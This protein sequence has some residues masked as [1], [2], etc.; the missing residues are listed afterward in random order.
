MKQQP[1]VGFS[2]DFVAGYGFRRVGGF[3]ALVGSAGGLRLLGELAADPDRP[4]ARPQDAYRAFLY[5][6]QP[7]WTLR[8]LQISW[9]DP[10]PRLA[11]QQAVE[12]WPAARN[13][14]LAILRDG[15]LLHLQQY[16]LPFRRRTIVE[17][18]L[19]PAGEE[20]ALDWWSAASGMFH[21]YQVAFSYLGEE[22]IVEIARRAL[23]PGF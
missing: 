7:G 8:C 17:F 14:G 20:E 5:S 23:N 13:E 15:L 10:D 11:F 1:A 3:I 9:P 22:E 16:P 18:L 12:Q 2:Q 19:P 4:E 21:N 6:M